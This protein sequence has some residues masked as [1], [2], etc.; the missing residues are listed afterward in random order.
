MIDKTQRRETSISP[1]YY[2][3]RI[4]EGFVVGYGLDFAENYR[5]LPQLCVLDPEDRRNLSWS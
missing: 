1:D 2:G 3:F 5:T 4:T